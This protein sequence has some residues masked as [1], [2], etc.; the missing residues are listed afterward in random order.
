M[1]RETRVLILLGVTTVAAFFMALMVLETLLA[2]AAQE[3][4]AAYTDPVPPW[5]AAQVQEEA[6]RITKGEVTPDDAP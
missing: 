3:S 1:T 2:E 4:M 5:M 6:R